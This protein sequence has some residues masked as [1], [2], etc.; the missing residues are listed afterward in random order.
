MYSDENAFTH[1]AELMHNDKVHVCHQ[2]VL[3]E[4]YALLG[5][6]G[7]RTSSSTKRLLDIGAGQGDFLN[8]AR[9]AGFEVYGNEFSTSAIQLAQDH[10]NI[11]L[12]SH[13]LDKDKRDGYFDAVTMWGLLEH[14][15]EPMDVLSQ[16]AR[17]LKPGGVLY[18][19]TPVWC[20][21]DKL[22]LI[23][24]RVTH[25]TRLLDRRITT[26]HLQIFPHT[27]LEWACARVGL[28]VIECKEVC[29]YNLPVVT[30]LESLGVPNRARNNLGSV[31]EQLIDRNLFF[32]NNIR[33]LCQK[34]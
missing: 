34:K 13:S 14:V 33:V 4:I 9:E 16:A 11:R 15:R 26:A 5:V 17:L 3:A 12:D 19:Y 30:Y 7:N 18:I 6:S 24:A 28:D 32:R 1:F 23:S 10:Y 29:E 27:T 8:E 2:R 20:L 22:G 21:Y 31:V 25:W